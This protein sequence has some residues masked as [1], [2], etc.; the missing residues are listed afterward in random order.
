[1][2][3]FHMKD[4]A[5]GAKQFGARQSR[6]QFP[7]CSSRSTRLLESAQYFL[8]LDMQPLALTLS[9][10]HSYD[11]VGPYAPSPYSEEGSTSY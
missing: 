3:L 1:M 2:L 4:G 5:K 6:R 11:L 10:I 8:N 7:S 9:P